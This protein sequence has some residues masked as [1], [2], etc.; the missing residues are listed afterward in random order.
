[1]IAP[2]KTQLSGRLLPM[3]CGLSRSRH[4]RRGL[5]GVQLLWRRP[6]LVL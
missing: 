1:M 3:S 2:A 4:R 6:L 5:G